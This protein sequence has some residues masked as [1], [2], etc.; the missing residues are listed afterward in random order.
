LDP[1]KMVPDK[2]R[3]I[4]IQLTREWL[5]SSMDESFV[6]LQKNSTV[7]K[8]EYNSNLYVRGQKTWVF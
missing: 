1:Y 3:W 5:E 6:L 4:E 7:P 2:K 8:I